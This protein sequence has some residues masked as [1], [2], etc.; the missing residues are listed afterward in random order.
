M[1]IITL[2]DATSSFDCLITM[3]PRAGSTAPVAEG[4]TQPVSPQVIQVP[5][6]T[7]P[8]PGQPLAFFVGQSVQLQVTA[9]QSPTL[10]AAG[11]LPAG[12]KLDRGTG[13]ISGKPTIA[14]FSKVIFRAGNRAGIGASKPVDL[15]I[16][17]LPEWISGSYEALVGRSTGLNANL[18]GWLTFT[19]TST[20]RL[21]GMVRMA[22]KA[23]PLAGAVSTGQSYSSPVSVS[24][25]I[26][27]PRD[28]TL[29]LALTL[30]ESRNFAGALAV[31]QTGFLS[32]VAAAVSGWRCPYTATSNSPPLA[33]VHHVAL[34]VADPSTRASSE[35]PLG[36]GFASITVTFAGSATWSGILAD[37]T[38]FTASH[39]LGFYDKLLLHAMHYTNTGSTQGHFTLSEGAITA[40]GA[41]TWFKS[42]QPDKI[43]TRSYKGGFGPLTLDLKGARYVKP[44]TNVRL[45]EAPATSGN[46]NVGFD[47]GGLTNPFDRTLTL[48]DKNA[49]SFL[50][51]NPQSVKLTLTPATGRFT[52]SF[53]LVENPTAPAAQQIK[54]SAHFNGLIIQ[55]PGINQGL[56]HFNLGEL[57]TKLT[58]TPMQSGWVELE[59]VPQQD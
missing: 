23:Y 51:P 8:S 21:T 53:L 47:L 55:A 50:G 10:F 3:K 4:C 34:K 12:L 20:G 46:A 31:Q 41:L 42:P 54:R 15:L 6:I 29:Q 17:P 36:H 24:L 11:T 30:D 49:V 37:G 52:G 32:A 16:K 19:I 25:N 38:P 14:S 44:G 26:P 2:A 35:I 5:V 27:R 22:G 1:K 43:T 45:L 7:S 57:G 39:R 48:S 28:T 18:G 33:G 58:T 40:P 9:S 13:L 56:G 59:R